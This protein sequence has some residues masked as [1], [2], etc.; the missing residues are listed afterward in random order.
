MSEPTPATPRQMLIYSA[1]AATVGIYFGMVGLRLLPIPGGSSNLHAPLWL[2]FCVGLAFTLAGVALFIQAI[3]HGNADGEL[4]AAAPQWLRI[5]QFLAALTIFVLFAAIASWVAFGPGEREF[6]GTVT[7][8]GHA[9]DLAGR[10]AFGFGAVITW[11]SALAFGVYGFRKF[12]RRS[13]S[14]AN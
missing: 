13:A 3:G 7:I 5:A 2:V 9:S 6:S 11:L 8:G 12:V 1:I 4:P 14:G 10:I